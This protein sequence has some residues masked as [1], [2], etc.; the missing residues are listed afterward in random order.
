MGRRFYYQLVD[1]SR[2]SIK[3]CA[4]QLDTNVAKTVLFPKPNERK[5]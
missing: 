1:S 4:K 3:D 5:T 2:T